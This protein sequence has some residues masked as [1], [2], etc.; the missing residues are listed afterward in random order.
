MH[1]VFGAA[2]RTEPTKA[3]TPHHGVRCP[4]C[5][6]DPIAPIVTSFVETH[7]AT[8][9]PDAL[10]RLAAS[11]AADHG[12]R[13]SAAA[14]QT[15]YEQHAVN[16]RLAVTYTL[17]ELRAIRTLLVATLE[18]VEEANSV[19]DASSLG[20]L[21]RVGQLEEKQKALLEALPPPL[22][23]T[24]GSEM[25]APRNDVSRS[26]ASPCRHADLEPPPR[27]MDARSAE[28]AL[29]DVIATMVEP[30]SRERHA[31]TQRSIEEALGAD[32]SESESQRRRRWLADFQSDAPSTRRRCHCASGEA[33][34]VLIGDIEAALREQAPSAHAFFDKRHDERTRAVQRILGVPLMPIRHRRPYRVGAVF[35]WRKRRTEVT[36][37]SVQSSPPRTPPKAPPLRLATKRPRDALEASSSNGD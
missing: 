29:R 14:I 5:R 22:A 7:C 16:V 28:A 21:L 20:L 18:R 33:C 25:T 32:R 13:W 23:P 4:A 35:G 1:A 6:R 24:V 3:C 2:S 11:L 15:H 19:T 10:W 37:L 31:V 26:S 12:V 9:R 17:R 30:C 34:H 8:T 27:P 36:P